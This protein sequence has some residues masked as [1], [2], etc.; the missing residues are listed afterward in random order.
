VLP[1]AARAATGVFRTIA[2]LSLLAM[3]AVMLFGDGWLL[4]KPLAQIRLFTALVLV[5]ELA[6]WLV[7]RAF[8]ART[9]VED[10]A[11][12]LARG[13]YRITLPLREIALVQVW[14]WP[15]PAPGATLCMASGERHALAGADPVALQAALGAT[16][17]PPSRTAHLAHA[18]LAARADRHRWAWLAHPVMK[19][20]LLPLLFAIPAFRLHQHIAYGGSFGEWQTFGAQAWL[21]GFGLWWAAWIIGVAIAAA[22]LRA[23]IEG[24]TVLTLALKP[25]ALVPARR[26]FERVG[27]VVLYLGLPAWLMARVLMN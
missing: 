26:L 14:R 27:L 5:P 1:P 16:P 24:A 10:G 9:S 8:Q 12:V 19:F 11:L 13:G 20:V 18:M 2:R 7:L 6:A 15:L 3:G 25:S 22:V 21:I 23:G 4:S 17:Q